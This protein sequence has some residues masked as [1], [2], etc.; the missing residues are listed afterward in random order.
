MTMKAERMDTV[1][2]AAGLGKQVSSP[3]GTLAI[4]SDVSLA[5]LR[6]RRWP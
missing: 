5:I 6:A 4:L 1:L 3:E 2:E